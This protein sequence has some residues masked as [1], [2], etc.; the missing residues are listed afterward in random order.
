MGLALSKRID[1]HLAIVTFEN[2]MENR[3][4]KTEFIFHNDRGCQCTSHDFRN[5]VAN[6]GGRKS[7]SAAGNPNDNAS[8]ESFFKTLKVEWLERIRFKTRQEATKAVREYMLY[9]NCGRL[10]SSLG[11]QSPVDYEMG[12]SERSLAS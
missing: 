1:R 6:S 12:I 7:M 5:A 3:R 9:Y 11:Y 10:H 2:A 8:A 4:P